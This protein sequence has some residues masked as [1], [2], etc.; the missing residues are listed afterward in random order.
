MLQEI[1]QAERQE[2]LEA[3]AQAQHEQFR[4]D[5]RASEGYVHPSMFPWDKDLAEAYKR[6]NRQQAAYADHILR[7][8][9]FAIVRAGHSRPAVDFNDEQHDKALW[10]MARLEHGRWNA[11]RLA[12]GWRYGPE[13][14][15]EKKTSPHL[16]PWQK[17]SPEIRTWDRDPFKKLPQLLAPL[18][19]KIVQL[20]PQDVMPTQSLP[21]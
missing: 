7:T 6:S 9:G 3:L 8:E 1:A 15:L 13:R 18:D 4:H 17:L 10:R 5:K 2:K 14:S 20:A 12:E 11:E 19:L 21:L 16:L